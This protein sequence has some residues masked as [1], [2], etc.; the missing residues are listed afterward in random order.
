MVRRQ[1]D[2]PYSPRIFAFELIATLDRVDSIPEA[3]G[4][5]R[6]NGE[7]R[8]VITLNYL[9]VV[10]CA[11]ANCGART[12]PPGFIRRSDLWMPYRT[13]PRL[14]TSMGRVADV[15]G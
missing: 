12:V 14:R 10:G 5:W 9:K 7:Q 3:A 2:C 13:F 8:N 15:G 6:S 11:I 1:T 4:Q